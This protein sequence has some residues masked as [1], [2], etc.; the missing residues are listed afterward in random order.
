M[1]R[2]TGI[3]L[4][5]AARRRRWRI[6]HDRHPDPAVPIRVHDQG[7]RDHGRDLGADGALVMLSGAEGLVADGRRHQPCRAA[8]RGAGLHP[9]LSADRRCVLRGHGLCAGHG[10]SQGKQPGET[11][12]GDGHRIFGHVR[13]RRRDVYQDQDRRASGPYPVRQPAGGGRAGLVDGGVDLPR[14][15][16]GGSG[17]APRSVAARFR[18]HT[19]AGGWPAGARAAL[20]PAGDDVADHRGDAGGGG[21]HPVDR[22]A[23][24]TWRHC[25][26]GHQAVRPNADRRGRRHPGVGVSGRLPQLFYR[27]R[28]GADRYSDADHG[29]H[30][31]VCPF[32]AQGKSAIRTH[33][34][35]PR[36]A[37]RRWRSGRGSALQRPLRPVAWILVGVTGLEPVAR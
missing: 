15:H 31:R 20:W 12:Y 7:F 29:V 14:G 23:D 37:A 3:C 21:H 28:P 4:P 34:L 30:R 35:I 33:G 19:G 24:R 32:N 13:P 5:A 22:P 25:V 16:R 36:A 18:P 27:Q 26:S 1:R 6:G 8:G 2:G 11:R 9:E 17:Q 10:I